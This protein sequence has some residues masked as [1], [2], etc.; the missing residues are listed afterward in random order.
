VKDRVPLC[1]LVFLALLAACTDPK[2]V[3][4]AFSRTRVSWV[5]FDP[6]RPDGLRDL[7]GFE[8]SLK[9]SW[10]ARPSAVLA[11]DIAPLPGTGG[12]VAVSHLGLLIL[13]DST[14]VV[15]S[16]RPGAQ[17]PL[18]SYLTD[19]LFTWKGKVFV[20][21]GQEPPAVAPPA[22]LAWWAPGQGRLAFYPVPSQV[23]DPSRQVVA[24]DLPA[25]GGAILGFAWKRLERTG[26]V[27][28]G[29]VLALDTGAETSA[30]PP[31]LAH[32][33]P[34][35][36]AYAAVKARLTERLGLEVPVRAA[37][38]PGPLLL[39]TATGWVAVGQLGERNAR[40]YRLPELGTSGRY[41]GAV[42]LTRGWVFTWETSF[43]GYA[44]VA[45]LVHVPF[46]VLA[47]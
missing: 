43:R 10:V 29:S 33:E 42:A 28:E 34:T 45:G 40:L 8:Q 11:T 32:A 25:G 18:S 17:W 12:A 37:V 15:T 6:D 30:P 7:P 46:A 3:N 14:G 23:R 39:F 38:G 26:A 16:L 22:S 20:T 21:L 24:V 36:P 35:P 5:V 2:E 13:D 47:P 44:G 19:R 27:F 1:L 41:T 9:T 4:A 31:P